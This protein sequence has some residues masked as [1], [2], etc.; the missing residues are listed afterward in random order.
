[1]TE[2]ATARIDVREYGATGDGTELDTDALQCALDDCAESGGTVHVPP[3]EYLT[4]PLRVGDQTTLHLAAGATLLFAR[5]YNAFPTVES[6]WEGWNQVGFHPCLL[7]RDAE[8]VAITGQGTIDGQGDYWWEFYDAPESEYPDGLR[9]RL[10]EFDERN[11]KRDDVSS[12][13]LRPPLFQI[14]SSENVSVS[15]VTLRNSPFWNTHLVYSENITVHDVNVENPADAPNGDGIDIDSSRYVRISDTYVNA[16]DDAIC[17]K[18]GKDEEGRSV[19]EPASQITITNCTIEAGHGGIVIG[20]EMSGDVRDVTVSNCTFTDTDR[21]IRLKTQRGRGGVV[22]DLRFDTIIMRRVVCPFVINGYY[23]TDI[24]IDPVPVDESTPM[25]RNVHFH[26]IT[27][28][29][30]S[31]AGFFAGVPEQQFEDISFSNVHIDATRPLDAT[32]IVPAMAENYEASHTFFC[33]SLAD[34]SFTDV[35][36]RTPEVPAFA[37]EEIDLVSMD[38]L[39][40]RGERSV[41]AMTASDVER[42]QITGCTAQ[43]SEQAFLAVRGAATRWVSLRGNHGPLTD[44][45][46]VD[47]SATNATIDSS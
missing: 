45:V 15:G 13:T 14:D 16:G 4:A 18:S 33:K 2:S 47:E 10:D 44:W 24:D 35:K 27:A 36:I 7:V 9:A 20:S 19:G 3:G 31:Y 34:I 6:R 8:N 23:F 37:F 32:D 41:P 12:F 5:D 42:I 11:D 26:N 1:M 28:R 17:I 46:A 22:E 21:G 25:V 43:P 29:D 30:V 39:D 40:V 38:G